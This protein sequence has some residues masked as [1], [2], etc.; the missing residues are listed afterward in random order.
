MSV[1]PY[2]VAIG[3]VEINNCRE[4]MGQ[5]VKL[6]LMRLRKADGTRNQ[7]QSAVTANLPDL[8]ASW[9][10]FL[11]ASDDTKV[12]QTPFI[13]GFEM[14]GGDAIL[15][16]GGNATVGGTQF[17]VGTNPTTFEC[18]V[19]N[20]KSSVIESLKAFECESFSRNLGAFIITEDGKIF[21]DSDNATTPTEWYPIP[22][23]S[24]F[25]GPKM[26]GGKEAT[27]KNIISGAFPPAWSD[28]LQLINPTDFEAKHDL[29]T[30]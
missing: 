30:P 17:N 18:H 6:V 26:T 25:V 23:E 2:P 4:K 15:D 16:G 21:S 10:A 24:L 11:A 13:H 29:V 20:Q 14:D 8:L 28:K 5:V 19:I 12:V 3:D 9:T 7:F 22:L 1:C 27:D